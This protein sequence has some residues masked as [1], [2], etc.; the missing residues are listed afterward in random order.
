VAV[1]RKL[2]EE[3]VGGRGRGRRGGTVGVAEEGCFGHSTVNW[4]RWS[5]KA[6]GGR[7]KFESIYQSIAPVAIPC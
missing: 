7:W 4:G 1:G 2:I 5:W 3:D 6:E